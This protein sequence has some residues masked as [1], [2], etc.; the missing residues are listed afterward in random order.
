MFSAFSKN[1]KD[2]TL[3]EPGLARTPPRKMR[4]KLFLLVPFPSRTESCALGKHNDI[5]CLKNSVRGGKG[6]IKNNF[7]HGRRNR[8]KPASL[9]FFSHIS[10]NSSFDLHRKTRR[11]RMSWALA[12]NK[13]GMAALAA[14]MRDKK[15]RGVE[16]ASERQVSQ[17]LYTRALYNSNIRRQQITG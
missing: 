11:E 3:T 1:A 8:W 9:T 5:Q 6:T 14:P 16:S 4:E 13:R 17:N 12:L 15:D 7:S 10:S 2:P